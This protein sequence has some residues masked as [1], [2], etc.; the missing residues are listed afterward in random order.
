MFCSSKKEKY[1]IAAE[2]IARIIYKKNL[3]YFDMAIFEPP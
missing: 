2:F 1:R 3:K